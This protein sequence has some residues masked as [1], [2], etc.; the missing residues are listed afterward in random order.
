MTCKRGT[1]ARAERKKK[2]RTK[3]SLRAK[4]RG[5]RGGTGKEGEYP[6]DLVNGEPAASNL[7]PIRNTHT[8][9]LSGLS[10]AR[11]CVNCDAE[12]QPRN[13]TRASPTK[14]CLMAAPRDGERKR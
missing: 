13:F 7:T 2:K 14:E 10:S 1:G 12:R 8:K 11:I 4:W 9:E 5:T 3:E 6:A